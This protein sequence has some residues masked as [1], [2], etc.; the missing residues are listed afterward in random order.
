MSSQNL[1]LHIQLPAWLTAYVDTYQ[2]STDISERMSF[3][4]GASQK[5]IDENT[6]GPFAA[7]IFESDT[8]KLISLGVN[9][10]NSEKLSILHAEMVAISLAQRQIDNYDL[11]TA[12]QKLELIT[13]TEPCAMCLGAIPWSGIHRVITGASG[14]D[15]E[16]IGFDEGEK[17]TVWHSGLEKRGIEVISKI[18]QAEAKAV[19]DSYSTRNG[20]IY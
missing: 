15:A 9:L 8:G 20:Q 17:P 16:A 7:G 6:G 5:N 1:S 3:V 10:V 19:L 2:Q 11:S 12:K 4:I 18:C 13:S 14:Q